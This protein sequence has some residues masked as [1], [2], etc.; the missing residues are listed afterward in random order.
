MLK[1]KIDALIMDKA[2]L[3]QCP[4]KDSK[5]K[6]DLGFDSLKIVELII[7]IEE[8]FGIEISDTDL[9]PDNLIK[10]SDLYMLMERYLQAA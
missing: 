7:D 9:D 1:E 4:N 2:F 6:E 8:L 3:E 10:V 5:L